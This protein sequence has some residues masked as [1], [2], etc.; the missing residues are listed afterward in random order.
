MNSE[1]TKIE[2]INLLNN[3]NVFTLEEKRSI[4]DLI[5]NMKL[6]DDKMQELGRKLLDRNYKEDV[7][8]LRSLGGK[9]V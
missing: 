2:I 3:S 1:L 7:D 4:I 8:L 6:S 9:N 5:I